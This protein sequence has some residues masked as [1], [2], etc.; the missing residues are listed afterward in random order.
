[1]ARAAPA[2]G[3]TIERAGV[4]A[5]AVRTLRRAEGGPHR[6]LPSLGHAPAQAVAADLR[7][8]FPAGAPTAPP[9]TSPV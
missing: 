1:M 9:P 5:A 4:R 8:A 6:S 3:E 7:P 2:I